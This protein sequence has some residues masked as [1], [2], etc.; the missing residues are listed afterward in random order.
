MLVF[1]LPAKRASER[2]EIWRKLK[3]SGALPFGTS[4]HLLPFTLENHERFE[5]L[6][7]SVRRYQ[8]QASV[9]QVHSIDDL[10]SEE[11]RKRFLE[12]RAR[13]YERLIAELKKHARAKAPEAQLARLR[14]RCQEI[15]AVD[16]F[17]TSRRRRRRSGFC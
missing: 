1:S 4:G 5:W 10:P 2:V 3:R 12:A 17:H 8:G 16:F 15:Q 14:R 9:V 6:A 13:D 7:A 11:I